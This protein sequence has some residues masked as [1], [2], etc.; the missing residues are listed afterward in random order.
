MS[1][2]SINEVVQGLKDQKI[3]LTGYPFQYGTPI[4]GIIIGDFYYA[5]SHDKVQVSRFFKTPV[6]DDFKNFLSKKGKESRYTN[7]LYSAFSE[8]PFDLEKI[9][10]AIQK[11]NAFLENWK[12][13]PFIIYETSKYLKRTYSPL[14]GFTA[15]LDG[16]VGRYGDLLGLWDEKPYRSE[17]D[18]S[19]QSEVFCSIFNE[20]AITE[21][22]DEVFTKEIQRRESVLAFVKPANNPDHTVT[23][24]DNLRSITFWMDEKNELFS[25]EFHHSGKK[26]IVKYLYNIRYAILDRHNAIFYNKAKEVWDLESGRMEAQQYQQKYGPRTIEHG[27]LD[28][29][30][31]NYFKHENY[32]KLIAEKKLKLRGGIT[33]DSYVLQENGEMYNYY[34]PELKDP[35]EFLNEYLNRDAWVI[36]EIL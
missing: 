29:S 8:L 14:L 18:W 23:F 35:K 3:F 28:R 10:S 31:L 32:R 7:N 33:E 30:L 24:K 2:L 34:D 1:A 17:Y 6:D 19:V 36:M 22:K 26:R 15:P 4:I 12:K 13:N 27:I 5:I 21:V 16:A 9:K 20:F 25:F 11:T